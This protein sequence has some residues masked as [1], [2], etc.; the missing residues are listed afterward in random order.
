[1]SSLA[2]AATDYVKSLGSV[3]TDEFAD[4]VRLGLQLCMSNG[5]WLDSTSAWD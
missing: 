5:A 4:S 1:M 3:T 2:A